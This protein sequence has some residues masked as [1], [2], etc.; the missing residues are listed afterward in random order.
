VPGPAL[1]QEYQAAISA[2]LPGRI[3]EELADGLDDTYRSYLGQGLSPDAAARAA[4]A[5]FGEPEI[6][7]AA[8]TRSSPSRRIARQLLAI[9]PAVGACWAAVLI[10]SPAWSWP[11]PVPVRVLAGAALIV[12]IA[13]LGIAASA[14]RYLLARRA[15]AAACSG[16]VV[17]DMLAVSV[18]VL[19]IWSLPWPVILALPASTF[20]AGFIARAIRSVLVA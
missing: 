11:V 8:F 4:V 17:L 7:A 9:G 10:A 19:S 13:M 16:L 3:A 14:R 20:R 12:I 2:R 15:A 5:E 18:A 6:V 1:I